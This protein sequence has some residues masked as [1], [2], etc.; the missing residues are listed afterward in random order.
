MVSVVILAL[1]NLLRPGVQIY[2]RPHVTFDL[3]TLKV[4]CFMPMPV[5]H[6]LMP[7]CVKIGSFVF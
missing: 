5:D 3:L 6:A 7:I 4:D 1:E 2:L